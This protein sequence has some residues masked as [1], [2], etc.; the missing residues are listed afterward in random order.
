MRRPFTSGAPSHA[1]DTFSSGGDNRH[2]SSNSGLRHIRTDSSVGLP[3]TL[4]GARTTDGPKR[5]Y[6]RP[7]DA[8]SVQHASGTRLSG[9]T[10]SLRRENL[11]FGLSVFWSKPNTRVPSATYTTPFK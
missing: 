7:P 8:V 11:Y 5:A 3:L 2:R 9:G 10:F 4:S 1:A 6:N